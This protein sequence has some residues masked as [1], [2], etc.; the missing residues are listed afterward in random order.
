MKILSPFLSSFLRP[1]CEKTLQEVSQLLLTEI[2][3]APDAPGGMPEFRQ[4]LTT[5]FFFKFYLTVLSHLPGEP[6]AN[7]LISA[8]LPFHRDQV[9]STQ[10][11]QRVSDGQLSEDTVGRPMM[12]LSALQQ[13]TGEAR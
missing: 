1:W 7:E 12:H 11:F 3:L 5:S 2:Q 9:K 6:L 4:S 10:G 13:A 8:T